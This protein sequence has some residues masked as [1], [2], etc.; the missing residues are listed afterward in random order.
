M[1]GFEG[2]SNSTS[3]LDMSYIPNHFTFTSILQFGT[4]QTICSCKIISPLMG[5]GIHILQLM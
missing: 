2:Y 1:S 3:K 4:T 5:C